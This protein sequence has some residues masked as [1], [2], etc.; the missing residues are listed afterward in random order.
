MAWDPAV[1]RK[2]NITGHFRLLNQLR[3]ELRDHP[4]VR[5][6]QGESV[7]VA[8]R[9]KALTRI[10]EGRSAT[11]GR[12]SRRPPLPPTPAEVE[13]ADEGFRTRLNAVDLR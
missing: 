7:G 12:G 9:S 4:L 8:N 11:A 10:L 6:K 13:P 2:H 5:P 3:T 1:L